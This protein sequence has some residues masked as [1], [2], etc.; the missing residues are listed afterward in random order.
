MLVAIWD[1]GVALPSLTTERA[2]FHHNSNPT[3]R[4][5]IL[6]V[7]PIVHATPGRSSTP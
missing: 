5:L 7:T 6:D 4:S 1:Y 2:E 3:I